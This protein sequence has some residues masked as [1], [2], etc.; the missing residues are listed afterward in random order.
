M[1][2]K[3]R[4]RRVVRKVVK[5][6][7]V[8]GVVAGAVYLAGGATVGKA[9]LGLASQ[10][11]SAR[12]QAGGGE[13]QTTYISPGGGSFPYVPGMM[14]GAVEGGYGGFGGGGAM[15]QIGGEAP[16]RSAF[17]P[18]VALGIGGV[19]LAAILLIALTRR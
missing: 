14:G 5:V 7:A 12:R 4:L 17:T 18:A 8:A 11:L 1:S 19:G 3:K 13:A 6:A 16:P 2:L 10:R 9:A 15:Q